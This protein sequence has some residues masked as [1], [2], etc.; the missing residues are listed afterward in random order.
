[1]LPK[2]RRLNRVNFLHVLNSSPKALKTADFQIR[3][4]GNDE[5]FNRYSVVIP[6]K[7]IKLAVDRNALKRKIYNLIAGIPGSRDII[8]YPKNENITLELHSL[9]SKI[10]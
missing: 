6:K 1:M 3:Y 5:K 2:T 8:I 9:V 10:S 4:V 7:I